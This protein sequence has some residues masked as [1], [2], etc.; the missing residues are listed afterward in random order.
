MRYV[1]PG[2]GIVFLLNKMQAWTSRLWTR[3]GMGHGRPAAR[4]L[5][6]GLF[7]VGLGVS[8]RRTFLRLLLV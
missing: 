2:N 7:V 6:W 3:L 8:L 1:N 5:A 4:D